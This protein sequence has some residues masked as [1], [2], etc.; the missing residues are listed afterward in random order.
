[1]S[2]REKVEGAAEAGAKAAVIFNEETNAG[3]SWER[4]YEETMIPAIG[5][6]NWEGRGLMR[7]LETGGSVEVRLSKSPLSPLPSR[8]IVADLEQ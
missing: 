2:L 8:N 3:A 4:L 1:M 6:G 7:A 5:I